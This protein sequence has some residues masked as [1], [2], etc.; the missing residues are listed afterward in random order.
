MVGRM[1]KTAPSIMTKNIN[2]K[3]VNT[4]N[5]S[6]LEKN[7]SENTGIETGNFGHYETKLL[8]NQIIVLFYLINLPYKYL[9]F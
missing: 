1:R 6:P 7:L 4:S 9:L 3:S 2:I 8:M 5:N